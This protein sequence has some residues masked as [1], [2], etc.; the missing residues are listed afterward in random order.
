MS[1]INLKAP[2]RAIFGFEAFVTAALADAGSQVAAFALGD[3]SLRLVPLAGGEPESLTLHDGAILA[4]AAHPAGGFVSAGD[5]GRVLRVT[6]EAEPTELARHPGQ[7]IEHLVVTEGGGVAYSLGREIHRRAPNGAVL[8]PLAPH[9]STVAGLD[10][11]GSLLAAAHYNGV[12]LWDLAAAEPAPRSLVWKGSHIAVAL[13]PDL[14]FVAT[15][16]QD[17]EVHGWRLS[18]GSEMRMSGYPAKV[19]SLSWSHDA[20]LLATSGNQVLVAWPFDGDGPEGRQPLEIADAKGALATRV[21]CHPALPLIA[22]GFASGWISL[23]DG[24]TK[25][26]ARFQLSRGAPVSALAWSADGAH[27]MAGAEDGRVALFSD[28]SLA[29]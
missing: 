16:L 13:S 14:R 5:D 23:T 28:R 18:N 19:K 7:W 21:A 27:L 25:R 3:G 4:L 24:A 2:P 15:S 9:P 22:G 8:P 12:T 6:G 11:G 29:R 17:G 26:G 20:S 1:A 10:T